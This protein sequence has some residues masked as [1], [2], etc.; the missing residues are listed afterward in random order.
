MARA[1]AASAVLGATIAACFSTPVR[2]GIDD[3]GVTNDGRRVDGLSMDAL[4]NPDG[5]AASCI[6]ESFNGSGSGSC[7]AWASLQASGGGASISGGTLNL[8]TY[9]SSSAFVNCTSPGSAWNRF[10][11]EVTDV[12]TLGSSQRTFVGIQSADGISRWGLEFYDDAGAVVYDIL[13][14]DG[15][16]TSPSRI[17]WDPLKHRYIQ[18]ERTMPTEITIS[19]SEDNASFVGVR[20]CAP[21]AGQ[22]A[23]TQAQLRVFTLFTGSGTVS[24]SE[25]ASFSWLELCHD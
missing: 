4:L 7:S 5:N 22:L 10:T 6:V 18:V 16:A 24:P 3:S 15:T 11:T 1:I 8:A 13:C 2:P 17:G 21:T 12:A 19:T 20:T 23:G 9:G 25:V 14:D